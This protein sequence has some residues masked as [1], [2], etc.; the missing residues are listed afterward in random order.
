MENNDYSEFVKFELD[1]LNSVQDKLKEQFNIN[2]YENWFYDSDS[3]LLRLYNS[4]EDEIFFK[5]ISIG[6]YS[7]NSQTWMWSWFNESSIET[8]KSE[9][10]KIKEFGSRQNYEKLLKG[11]FPSDEY[12]S[13]EFLAVSYKILGGIGAY[14]VKVDHLE[15]YMLLT[16]AYENKNSSEIRKLKQKTVD[17]KAHG[18]K[19]RAFLC[20]HLD[21]KTIKGFSESFDTTPGME[22]EDGDD[23]EAWCDE[24]EKVRLE[25]DGWN[26]ESMI[27]A[28]IKL[29]CEDCFFKHKE[30]NQIKKGW[31]RK[32]F[33]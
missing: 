33:S 5:Y 18:Y 24:C 11:T 1:K 23:F 28:N 21:L 14:R 31:L 25:S 13:W 26:D 4:D 22:L 16:E 3:S 7:T 8:D 32:L 29:V 9:T 15:K 2:S 27:F 30:F 6:T 10:L 17:C 12:D 19:R 20:Q